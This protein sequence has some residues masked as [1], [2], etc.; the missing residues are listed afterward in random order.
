MLTD[1]IQTAGMQIEGILFTNQSVSHNTGIQ[2]R[3]KVAS[4]LSISDQSNFLA[5]QLTAIFTRAARTRNLQN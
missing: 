3:I 5:V 2:F 1:V 4:W